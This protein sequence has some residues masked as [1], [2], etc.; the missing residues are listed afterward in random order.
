[1]PMKESFEKALR[2]ALAS[3]PYYQLLRISLD[4]IDD[5]FAHFRMPFRKEWT[6][7]YGAVHG[8]LSLRYY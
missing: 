7:A 4:Q 1:M 6:Q 8:G 3:A 2:S 5:G